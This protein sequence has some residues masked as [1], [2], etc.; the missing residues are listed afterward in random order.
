MNVFFSVVSEEHYSTLMV[1]G[2]VEGWVNI[3]N[4]TQILELKSSERSCKKWENFPLPFYGGTGA[5]MPN[6]DIIVCWGRTWDQPEPFQMNDECHKLSANLNR[7][8]RANR[9]G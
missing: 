2:G 1:L 7:R 4:D 9:K 8:P 6:G 3:Y 5:I